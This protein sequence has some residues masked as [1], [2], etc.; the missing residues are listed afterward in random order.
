MADN[1]EQR[2]RVIRNDDPVPEGKIQPFKDGSGFALTAND[3]SRYIALGN[4]PGTAHS[5]VAKGIQTGD[6]IDASFSRGGRLHASRH[7]TCQSTRPLYNEPTYRPVNMPQSEPA[8]LRPG[9][10]RQDVFK[11]PWKDGGFQVINLNEGT[12]TFTDKFQHIVKRLDNRTGRPL[13]LH[14]GEKG[15]KDLPASAG[16]PW[17]GSIVRSDGPLQRS[18]KVRQRRGAQQPV[19]TPSQASSLLQESMRA[20]TEATGIQPRSITVNNINSPL[21]I[22]LSGRSVSLFG[23]GGQK[24]L[25]PRVALVAAMHTAGTKVAELLAM[26]YHA[27]RAEAARDAAVQQNAQA[28]LAQSATAIQV[29]KNLRLGALELAQQNRGH[30]VHEEKQPGSPNLLQ[31]VF[32]H[33]SR[34]S[35]TEYKGILPGSRIS[36]NLP[37]FTTRILQPFITKSAAGA[38]FKLSEKGDSPSGRVEIVNGDVRAESYGVG[39]AIVAASIDIT[40]AIGFTTEGGNIT[41]DS[42]PFKLGD[43][44]S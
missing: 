14:D 12:T 35:R 30:L 10:I 7:T 23:G 36:F 39:G 26:Q 19:F 40:G 18:D 33:S 24:D 42:S 22:D 1:K 32:G 25:P 3:G 8:P 31:R 38:T 34:Q 9:E 43:D 41:M 44:W 28:L 5:L 15:F 13:P 16:S 20:V 21:V 29:A 37:D 11:E 2:V 4:N 27:Q 6:V 17:N